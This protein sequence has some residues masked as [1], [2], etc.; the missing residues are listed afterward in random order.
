MSVPVIKITEKVN[1]KRDKWWVSVF[2]NNIE[3]TG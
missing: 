2:Y 3:N 1:E